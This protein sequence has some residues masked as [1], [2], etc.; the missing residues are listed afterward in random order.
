MSKVYDKKVEPASLPVQI[1]EPTSIAEIP[2]YVEKVHSIIPMSSKLSFG[3][4]DKGTYLSE[5]QKK[6]E[7]KKFLTTICLACLR[8]GIP[9]VEGILG[10]FYPVG[11]NN[12]EISGR[13]MAAAIF[14]AGHHFTTVKMDRT[15]CTLV[16]YRAGNDK[17]MEV[18]FSEED[19]VWAGLLDEDD[20]SSKP[21]GKRFVGAAKKKGDGKGDGKFGPWYSYREDMLFWRALSRLFRR[22]YAD[23]FNGAPV[24]VEGEIDSYVP[25]EP[26][27]IDPNST[28]EVKGKVKYKAKEEPEKAPEKPP[29]GRKNE[30]TEMLKAVDGDNHKRKRETM[31]KHVDKLLGKTYESLEDSLIALQH[32][33]GAFQSVYDRLFEGLNKNGDS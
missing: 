2:D 17:P 10:S 26:S 13:A 1:K 16:G 28:P 33:E 11:G 18:S 23:L 32:D 24:Y 15:I 8:M 22:L 6:K 7:H 4:K 30:I 20:L 19:A 5:D 14:K 3:K 12:V 9:V 21:S 31:K 29:K 25:D 27:E